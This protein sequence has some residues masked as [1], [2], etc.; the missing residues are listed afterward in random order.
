[1]AIQRAQCA[2]SP[3]HL[4]VKP[5][6]PAQL[7]GVMITCPGAP[8]QLTMTKTRSLAF[9]QVN[10]SFCTVHLQG[11][12]MAYGH[13]YVTVFRWGLTFPSLFSTVLYTIGG[14]SNGAECVFPFI[15]QG[16]TY[17]GCTTDGRTDGYRWCATTKDFDQDKQYG[18]C[19]SRG[20]SPMGNHVSL[21][22]ISLQYMTSL[23]V[24]MSSQIRRWLG[25]T[26]R[27][28]PANF[29][30]P[31][32]TKHTLPAPVKVAQMAS[33]GVQRQ[34]A[35]TK[36]RNGDFVQTEVGAQQNHT[37]AIKCWVEPLIFWIW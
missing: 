3:S 31:S 15:F 2:T 18:F 1:M 16:E 23:H 9:A 19:P 30:L 25:E 14:N 32:W 6:L 26:L 8:L 28:S 29:L 20:N 5:T 11:C 17:N 36:T 34:A 35:T 21:L 13:I 22:M 33:C 4:R 7:R 37:G 10:V 12:T 24:F 27:E